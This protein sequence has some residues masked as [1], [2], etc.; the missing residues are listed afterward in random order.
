MATA[1][2]VE[3]KTPGRMSC[4]EKG[5]HRMHRQRLVSFAPL[6]FYRKKKNL[7]ESNF[8]DFFP[9][10]Q[11]SKGNIGFPAQGRFLG[12]NSLEAQKKGT[13]DHP[14]LC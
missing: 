10:S 5:P 9:T 14:W 7:C 2:A 3:L 6:S 1:A 4:R 11:T 8:S 12:K 13:R